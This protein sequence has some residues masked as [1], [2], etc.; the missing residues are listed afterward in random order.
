VISDDE[1]FYPEER[2]SR[3]IQNADAYLL[4]YVE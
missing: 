4:N 3:F 1:F 2:G